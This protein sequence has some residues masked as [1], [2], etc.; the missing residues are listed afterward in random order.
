MSTIHYFNTRRSNK[1]AT[2]EGIV[3]FLQN[4]KLPAKVAVATPDPESLRK[5]LEK[6]VETNGFRVVESKLIGPV[7]II[8][9]DR[10]A[11]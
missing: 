5:D 1:L 9:A 3:A 6:F 8:T 10:E 2:F 11:R 4:T 7:V